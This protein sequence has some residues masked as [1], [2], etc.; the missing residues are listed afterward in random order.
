MHLELERTHLI[1]IDFVFLRRIFSNIHILLNIKLHVGLYLFL[2][3][4][5]KTV[6]NFFTSLCGLSRAGLRLC[7]A[8]GHWGRHAKI[9]GWAK[10]LPFFPLSL[11]FPS[12]S[13][14][15]STL[16][17]PLKIGP[18]NTARRFGEL[19]KLQKRG[20]G[21][22]PCRKR[23]WCILALKSYIWLHQGALVTPL[24]A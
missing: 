15:F 20:L 21:Q 23:I 19:C 10:S 16:S 17:L 9:F 3:D 5:F 1:A 7:G 2:L 8:L 13:P 6:V 12:Y 24:A 18:F 11:S 4:I 22:S 14:P